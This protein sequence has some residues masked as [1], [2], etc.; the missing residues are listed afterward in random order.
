MVPEIIF[1]RPRR[2]APRGEVW[3]RRIAAVERGPAVTPRHFRR[4]QHHHLDDVETLRRALGQI[5]F[6]FHAGQARE[7]PPAG[8]AE[9][10]DRLAAGGPIPPF[11]GHAHSRSATLTS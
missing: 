1:A 8:I 4:M 6:G 10:E 3:M 11:G 7:H 9:P 2:I 5:S